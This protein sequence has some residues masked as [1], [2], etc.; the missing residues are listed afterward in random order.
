MTRRIRQFYPALVKITQYRGQFAG[1]G[2]QQLLSAS[3]IRCLPRSGCRVSSATGMAG[4][5]ATMKTFTVAVAMLA[6]IAAPAQAQVNGKRHQGD[7]RKAEPKKP[8]VD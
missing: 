7:E 2:H 1:L 6:L 8:A 3:P 5:T 4:S